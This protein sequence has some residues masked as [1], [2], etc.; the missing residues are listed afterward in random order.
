MRQGWTRHHRFTV[1]ET[2]ASQA[3]RPA[4]NAASRRVL[5]KLGMV[6]EGLHRR[7]LFI[8]EDWRD[9]LAYA[10]LV[11]DLPAAGVRANML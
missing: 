11:E 8:D 7:Y 6:Q 1:A 2:G 10:L 3:R 9:H 4:Q 5:E